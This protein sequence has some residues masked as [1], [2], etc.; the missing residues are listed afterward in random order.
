LRG[1]FE[2]FLFSRL[3]RFLMFPYFYFNDRQKASSAPTDFC[4]KS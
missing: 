4:V 2:T 1:L 3:F